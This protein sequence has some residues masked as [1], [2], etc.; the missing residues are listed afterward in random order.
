MRRRLHFAGAEANG[1]CA[2]HG[3]RCGP[4]D[5]EPPASTAQRAPGGGAGRVPR[6]RHADASLNGDLIILC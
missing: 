3:M 6:T 1:E 2:W 5:G 4:P